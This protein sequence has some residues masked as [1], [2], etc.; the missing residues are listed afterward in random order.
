MTVNPMGFV[1]LIF[2]MFALGMACGFW[3]GRIHERDIWKEW[4]RQYD[5]RRK[6]DRT[7]TEGSKNGGNGNGNR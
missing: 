1:G 7:A 4:W 5:Y 3:I 6:Q 2:F